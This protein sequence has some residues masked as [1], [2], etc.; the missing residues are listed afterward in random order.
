MSFTQRLEEVKSGFERSFWVAN[1][2]ELFERLSYY[3]AFASLARYL[4]EVTEFPDR[5][6]RESF[7]TVRRSGM[8]SGNFWRSDR[9]SAGIPAGT[10]AGVP[11]SGRCV[12]FAGLIGRPLAD[13]NPE[14]AVPLFG[15]RGVCADAAGVGHLDGK[16]LR[17]GN[18]GPGVERKCAVIGYSIYYT[19][20]NIG[21]S[22]GPFVASWVQTAHECGK[23]IPGFRRKRAC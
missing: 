22:L 9:R 4:H 10:F 12:F 15:T 8:V 7:R 2:S 6:R 18:Y 14:H 16:A 11:D 20:V 1:I 19:L 17:G 3:A 21:G 13:A 23:R 5:A